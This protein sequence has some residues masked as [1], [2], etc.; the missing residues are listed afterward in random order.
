MATVAL[1]QRL[2]NRRRCGWIGLFTLP[3]LLIGGCSGRS[4]T[5]I[6]DAEVGDLLV[7]AEGTEVELAKTF[8]PGVSNGLYK[9]AVRVSRDNQKSEPQ[10]YSI[11]AVCSLEGE[12]DWPSYDNM[13]GSPINE[14]A[15]A[16]EAS[17]DNRW[18]ILFH[19]DGR[20]ET[21]GSL[22]AEPWH[23]R[24]KNN[25]CRREEFND[26]TARRKAA[27]G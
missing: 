6:Q 12:V 23:E 18:Q 27:S 16:E 21:K 11:N 19:F 25:L 4:E 8:E 24:L 9:G 5:A 3:I 17:L 22:A 1:M 2:R 7:V 13:Y 15:Q 10:L 20:I 26:S 14:P